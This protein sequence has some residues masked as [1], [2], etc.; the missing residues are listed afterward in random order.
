MFLFFFFQEN[1][2]NQENQETFPKFG[3]LPEGKI[4]GTLRIPIFGKNKA[5]E[6]IEIR[7]IARQKILEIEICKRSFD[8][9][10]RYKAYYIP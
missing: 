5:G 4:F 6:N 1:Q 3:N 8:K 2:E 9:N 10:G 7:K